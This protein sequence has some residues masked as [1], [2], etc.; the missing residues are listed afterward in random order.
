M[1][2]NGVMTVILPTMATVINLVLTMYHG[3][4]HRDFG[5]RSHKRQGPAVKS[6]TG[7]L[8]NTA[9][10]AICRNGARYVVN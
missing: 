8:I 4:I 2:L 1:T 7:N 6:D 5:E 3:N 9:C 10:C